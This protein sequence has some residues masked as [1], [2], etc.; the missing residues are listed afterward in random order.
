MWNIHKKKEIKWSKISWEN[1]TSS[2]YSNF[3]LELLYKHCIVIVDINWNVDFFQN[4]CSKERNN[5][6]FNRSKL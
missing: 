4:I 2:T 3:I 6:A 5:M 1:L